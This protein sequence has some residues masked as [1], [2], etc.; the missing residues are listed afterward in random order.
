MLEIRPS[1]EHCNKK[2]PYNSIQ[3]MICSFECTYCTTCAQKLFKN[4][5]PNCTGNLTPRPIRPSYHIDKHPA[6]TTVIFDPKDLKITHQQFSDYGH[7]PPE[8]R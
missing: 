3:A 8:K 5:C 7:I 4:I 1:C 2:L 6:A